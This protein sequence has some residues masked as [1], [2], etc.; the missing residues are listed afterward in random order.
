MVSTVVQTPVAAYQQLIENQKN[1][2]ERTIAGVTL[3]SDLQH[4][5]DIINDTS[6]TY[7]QADKVAAYTKE[8]DTFAGSDLATHSSP[9]NA[10]QRVQH[11]KFDTVI[12]DSEIG[13]A[14]ID[15]KKK[16]VALQQSFRDSR[17]STRR[18]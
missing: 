14:V 18:S 3:N 1:A 10:D 15:G 7:S 6:G 12:A 5:A 4:L 8:Y 9:A 11:V 17:T 2:Y 13:Q 16:Y